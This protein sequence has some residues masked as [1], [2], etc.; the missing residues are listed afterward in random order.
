ML[1]PPLIESIIGLLL[2]LCFVLFTLVFRH[3]SMEQ[4]AGIVNLL[5]L[6]KRTTLSISEQVSPFKIRGNFYLIIQA[7]VISSILLFS[8]L[9]HHKQSMDVE[10]LFVLFGGVLLVTGLFVLLKYLLYKTI[11][12]FFISE[13]ISEWISRYFWIIK[14]LGFLLFIP[15]VVYIYVGELRNFIVIAAIVIFFITRMLIFVELLIIFVKNKIG[16]LY[17]FV[18]FC[19]T[20]IAPYILFVKGVIIFTKTVGIISI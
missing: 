16:L 1:F 17:F 19:G 3:E 4:L 12:T 18:Y 7:I 20:E 5:L 15:T 2:L 8:I 13:Q 10:N 6:R 14:T 11:G 9:V